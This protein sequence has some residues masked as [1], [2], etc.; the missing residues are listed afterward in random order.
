MTNDPDYILKSIDESTK[1]LGTKPDLYYLHRIDPNT[2]LDKSIK[3]LQSL[4]ESGKTRYI[5]LSECGPETLKKAC[6]RASS[7]PPILSLTHP[8]SV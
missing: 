4:K 7:V 2:P 1:R 8:S 5:G 3:T 6:G